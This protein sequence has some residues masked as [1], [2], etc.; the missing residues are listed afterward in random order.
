MSLNLQAPPRP[1][2]RTA[3]ANYSRDRLELITSCAREFEDISKG[4]MFH[5]LISGSGL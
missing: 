2:S 1:N 4:L 3:I 5:S